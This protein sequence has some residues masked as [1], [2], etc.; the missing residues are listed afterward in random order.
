MKF[1]K[2]VYGLSDPG[3]LDSSL[4][5]QSLEHAALRYIAAIK[6]IQPMGPYHL[7][8]FSYGSTLCL[9]V[10]RQLYQM[11]E[12]IEEIHLLDGLPPYLYQNIDL[13]AH[14]ELLETM[15]QFISTLLNNRYYGESV[16]AIRIKNAEKLSKEEQISLCFDFFIKK[17][18]NPASRRLLAM[19]ERHLHIMQKDPMSPLK[20]PLWPTLYLTR[21]DQDYLLVIKKLPAL[22]ETSVDYHTFFWSRYFCNLTR[23][24]I[25]LDISHLEVLH[26]GPPE[27][28]R[29]AES[30]WRRAFDPLFNIKVDHYGPKSFFRVHQLANEKSLVSVYFL[31]GERKFGLAKSLL[32]LGAETSKVSSHDKLFEKYEQRDKIY[33]FENNVFA[34][35]AQEKAETLSAYL[36]SCSID[37]KP[38]HG[39]GLRLFDQGV[40]TDSSAKSALDLQVIWNRGLLF[41]FSFQCQAL[42]EMLMKV[43]EEEL[44]LKPRDFSTDHKTIYY[45]YAFVFMDP[46]IYKVV[47]HVQE[48]LA[49]FI[50]V[51]APYTS[52]LVERPSRVR[53]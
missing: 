11:G 15:L 34:L 13:K 17:V 37:E 46:N 36:R 31:H 16:K 30:L 27:L 32:S 38:S 49:D 7:L 19:A 25:Q 10:A 18:T 20:L 40:K 42:P 6:T 44:Q 24:G 26:S 48:F 53:P 9:A 3:I 35:C 4:L 47:K 5:P 12:R 28:N 8:G 43:I 45:R 52:E 21:E 39:Y 23:C 1:N 50:A 51:L 41:T 2:R 29:S 14:A 22:A 33:S